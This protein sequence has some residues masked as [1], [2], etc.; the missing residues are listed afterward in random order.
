VLSLQVVGPDGVAQRREIPPV[1]AGTGDQ[2]LDRRA[3]ERPG[4]AGRFQETQL[5]QVTVTR[6]S[7]EVEQHL[8]DPAAGEHLTVVRHDRDRGCHSVTLVS[9][10]DAPPQAHQ[11]SVSA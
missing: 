3:Q 11:V 4:A 6:V 8:D 9:G 5:P 1:L 7:G 2:A 10:T